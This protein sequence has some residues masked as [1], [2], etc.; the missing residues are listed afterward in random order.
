MKKS[1]LL[2]VASFGVLCATAQNPFAEYNYTPKIASLSQGKYNET[3]DND[4]LVQ[5][6]SILFNTKSKQIVAFIQIDLST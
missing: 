5:I 6:G 2:F 4:T 1:F 3:F